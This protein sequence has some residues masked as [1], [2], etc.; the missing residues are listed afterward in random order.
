MTRTVGLVSWLLAIVCFGS[1]YAQDSKPLQLVFPTQNNWNIVSEGTPV[2][3]D[4]KATGSTTDTL[5]FAFGSD[6]VEGMHL[7]SLGHF[8]WTPGFGL[9]DRIQTTK[10]YPV[11][12]EVRNSHGQ[13]ASQ[14]VDFKVQHVNRPPVIDEL[15]PFYVSYR[16]QN[17]YKMDA[18]MVHDDDGDPIVFIPI[19]DQMPEGSKLSSQGE[20]TWTLSLN[21][22]NRLKQNPQYIEFWVEDQPSKVRTK[23]RLKV[24]VTQ[25]D[26]PPDISIIPKESHYKLRENATVNLKFYLSDLNGDDDVSTFGFLSDNQNI[27]KS[28]L[29]KN[30]NNQYEFIWQPGYEFVKDPYDSLNVQITF[31]VLDKAQNREE[32]RITFTILNTVNEAEKDR[33]YYAQYRQALVQAWG[34]VEQLSEKEEQL[35]RDYRKAKGGKRNRSVAN[36]SLGAITG[37][38]P[39][40]TANDPNS[41]KII[42]AVGGTAVLTMGTL[43]ATEVIGKSMKDLLDRYNYVLGKK[44]EL[45]NKGDVF[46]REFA[47]KSSRRNNEFIKKLDDFRNSMSLSGLVALELDAN[48]QSKKD[49]S[50]KAIKRTFKDFT[51]LEETQ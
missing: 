18:Q 4:L 28:A 36:A 33:Y 24:E 43:E 7:D 38:S 39:A 44:S 34:L 13:T 29:V 48:W 22:F 47:L 27:P 10:T 2:R 12:F 17:T 19:T 31:Y 25:M 3:F 32:K 16:T 5:L 42:S 14:T 50:D 46:A 26:L 11:T 8:T 40:I 51:P 30:T 23:G 6:P 20:L 9:A 49:S 35:K 21:Q 15:R 37:V 41:Q 45:Q 1:S